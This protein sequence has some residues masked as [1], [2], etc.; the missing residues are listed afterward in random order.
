MCRGRGDVVGHVQTVEGSQKIAE[1]AT[2]LP[3][4]LAIINISLNVIPALKG[5]EIRLC[6][7]VS[8]WKTCCHLPASSVGYFTPTRSQYHDVLAKQYRLLQPRMDGATQEEAD[9]RSLPLHVDLPET[10]RLVQLSSIV[11]VLGMGHYFWNMF[12]CV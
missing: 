6:Q 8:G 12:V 2:T 5:I 11:F 3:C 1:L 10:P 7:K 4:E 9:T